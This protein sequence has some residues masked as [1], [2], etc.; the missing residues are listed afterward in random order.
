MV[1]DLTKHSMKFFFTLDS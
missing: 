1:H